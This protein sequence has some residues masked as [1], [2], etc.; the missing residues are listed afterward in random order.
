MKK[1]PKQNSEENTEELFLIPFVWQKKKILYNPKTNK[2][3]LHQLLWK[4]LY[5][6]FTINFQL[7][8]SPHEWNVCLSCV[9]A[10]KGKKI[11]LVRREQIFIVFTGCLSFCEQQEEIN[12]IVTATLMML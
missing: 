4:K 3:I 10:K 5:G 8:K 12:D 7:M 6:V 2:T 9:R 1:R 11:A